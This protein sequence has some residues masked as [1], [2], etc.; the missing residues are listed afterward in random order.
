MI[1]SE[2]EEK[3]L[4]G[5]DLAGEG[6]SQF[7][8]SHGTDQ[9]PFGKSGIQKALGSGCKLRVVQPDIEKNTRINNPG[10]Y[11]RSPSRSKSIHPEVV[12]GMPVWKR[13]MHP[14]TE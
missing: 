10:H 6:R 2:L 7:D 1:N 9:Q 5:V 11:S 14:L 12:A 3:F 8:K 4:Q 13:F